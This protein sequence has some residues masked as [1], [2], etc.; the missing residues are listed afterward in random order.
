MPSAGDPIAANDTSS[1]ISSSSG[2]AL[3]RLVQQSAQS[4][5]H[6]TAT[7]LTFGAGSEDI[8]TNNYHD[9]STNPSRVTPTVAGYYLCRG[10]YMTSGNTDYS[11]TDC[12]IRK[13]ASSNLAGGT[14]DGRATLG[15]SNTLSAACFAT[16]TCDGVTDYIEL[17]V[18]HINGAAAARNTNA[19]SQFSSCLE[20][21]FLRPL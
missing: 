16:V 4:I 20:V 21:E 19:S 1:L 10:L 11:L 13:T 7:V 6:N 3:V 17:M 8:D 15:A 14:R 5:P 18:L 12:W 2:K 9:T